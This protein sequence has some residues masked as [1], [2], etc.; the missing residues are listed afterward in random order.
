MGI[1]A[2]SAAATVNIYLI[3]LV[4]DANTGYGLGITAFSPAIRAASIS[5]IGGILV[6]QIIKTRKLKL[7]FLVCV[8]LCYLIVGA[9][10]GLVNNGPSYEFGRHLFAAS[11]MLIGYWAGRFLTFEGAQ[12]NK[13]LSFWAWISVLAGGLA[14]LIAYRMI[15]SPAFSMSPV[16]QFLPLSV[17]LITGSIG[18]VA[19][20]LLM[21]AFGNKRD[22]ILGAAAVFAV[23]FV[24]GYLAKMSA[25]LRILAGAILTVIFALLIF[26]FVAQSIP[27]VAKLGIDLPANL[28]ERSNRVMDFVG[29]VARGDGELKSPDDAIQKD[30]SN[31]T[32][33]SEPNGGEPTE[34]STEPNELEDAQDVSSLKTDTKTQ[35][36][37]IP[38][39]SSNSEKIVGIDDDAMPLD[40][41]TTYWKLEKLTSARVSLTASVYKAVS[42]EK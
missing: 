23:L 17:G 30:S 42:E 4:V 39:D 25:G 16:S 18:L 38:G 9:I 21:I 13:T 34:R 37:E 41:N 40:F 11:T 7:D 2:L 6:L 32:E 36:L 28:A 24:R 20:P 33:S 26:L 31:L 5:I 10:V 15:E 12:I 14:W 27:L 35:E 8:L 3:F 1:I 29:E 19:L 22:V